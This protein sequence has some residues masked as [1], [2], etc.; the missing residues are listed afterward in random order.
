MVNI[1]AYD[2]VGIRVTDAAR[3]IAFYE[4]ARLPDR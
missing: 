1:T 2:H 4:K 3:S